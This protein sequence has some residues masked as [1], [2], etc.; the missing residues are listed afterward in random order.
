MTKAENERRAL[1]RYLREIRVFPVLTREEERQLARRIEAGDPEAKT[2]LVESNLGFVIKVAAEHR[3][4]GVPFEDLLNEGNL[5]L[6]EAAG[7]Y[8]ASKG[9][10]FITYA[11]WW[12]RKKILKAIAD[13]SLV[14]RVPSYQRKRISALR[15][16]EGV[17]HRKLGRS[18][19]RE[20]IARHLS[21]S[22]D[23]VDRVRRLRL[24]HT[25]L[26]RK[27]GGDDP[28]SLLERL[29]DTDDSVE[30]QLLSEEVRG[31]AAQAFRQLSPKEQAVLCWRLGLRER[32]PETL[33]QVGKRMGLSRERIR[34]I[35][36]QALRRLRRWLAKALR[37]DRPA[38]AR[39]P[40]C[41]LKT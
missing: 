2:R 14:V 9:T 16:A 39:E 40:D 19:T 30:Q 8:D 3:S 4:L 35:E 27:A 31:L 22:V 11:V 20:E 5:G 18:P 10:K 28:I 24:T 7:R 6:L 17:L 38:A 12:I 32:P 21:I 13:R 23:H 34:Q 33:M 26:D 29:A 41:R 15:H 37:E 1:S 25:S 36:N